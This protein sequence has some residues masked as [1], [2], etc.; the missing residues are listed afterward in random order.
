MI[1]IDLGPLEN[2]PHANLIRDMASK[3]SA[4]DSIQAI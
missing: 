3:C 4:D 2:G 1:D